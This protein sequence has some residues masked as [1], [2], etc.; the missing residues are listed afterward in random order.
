MKEWLAGKILAGLNS[1]PARNF[2][3]WL[4]VRPVAR[5]NHELHGVKVPADVAVYFGDVAAKNYQLEQWLPVLEKLHRHHPVVLVFRK[6][7]ALRAL[8]GKTGLPSIFVR[9]FEDLVHLYEDND[10]RLCLYVNNGVSNFQSLA[11]PR[12]VHVHINHG[13]SDKLSMVSNQAKAY[14]KV[15]IAGPAALER[16]RSVLV[17]FDESKLLAV[18]RPQLDIDFPAGLSPYAGRTVM[19]APTW[20]GENF[21]NNYTSV[22]VFGIEIANSIL[23]LA[24]TRLVYKPHPRVAESSD[25]GVSR[26]HA[27]I[28]GQIEQANAAGGGHVVAT[29]GNILTM[30]DRTDVLVTDVSSVGLDFL[31]LHPDRPLIITD[32]RNDPE[33]LQREAPVS[34]ACPIFD[35]GTVQNAGAIIVEASDD[36]ARRAMRL[37]MRQYYFGDL[38]RGESTQAFLAAVDKLISDRTRKLSGYEFQRSSLEAQE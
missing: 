4:G 3:G 18:G 12:M 27:A 30:F 9:R 21:A 29:A 1:A 23:S 13:E 7:A 19:Y 17:D 6:V 22:D 8:K 15:M 28:L 10:Y 31:Y 38:G 32:R 14:D 11:N 36:D 20:E 33:A 5:A 26:A 24:G 16:H 25:T 2:R 35:A 34:R 37:D